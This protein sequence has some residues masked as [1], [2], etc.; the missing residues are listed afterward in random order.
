MSTIDV[1]VNPETVPKVLQAAVQNIPKEVAHHCPIARIF[2][3][4]VKSLMS[5]PTKA[6]PN[7]EANLQAINMQ[8]DNTTVSGEASVA[9]QEIKRDVMKVNNASALA[10]ITSMGF[11]DKQKIIKALDDSDG[12]VNTAVEKLLENTDARKT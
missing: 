12:D 4:M 9:S 2:G 11:T 1:E 8:T 7:T 5:P 10:Y 3:T 6:T